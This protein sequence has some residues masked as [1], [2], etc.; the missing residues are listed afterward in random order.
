MLSGVSHPRTV[1]PA[2]QIAD[3]KV[4]FESGDWEIYAYVDNL[5]N[6]RAILF[7]KEN[8]LVPGTLSINSPQTWGLG[9][10]KSWGGT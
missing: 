2:Y 4:G 9:F 5:T 10:S 3:F 7:D 6:E 8:A 1:Q